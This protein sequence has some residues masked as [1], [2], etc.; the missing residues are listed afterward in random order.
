MAENDRHA[1]GRKPY[2]VYEVLEND[3]TGEPTLRF[4]CDELADA[5]DLALDYLRLDDPHRC[6]IAALEIVRAGTGPRDVVWSYSRSQVADRSVSL[7]SVW[8]FDPTR[9]WQL[10]AST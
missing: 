6:E 9:R 10:P 7:T 4:A 8:G 2:E 5:I 1:A 3:P